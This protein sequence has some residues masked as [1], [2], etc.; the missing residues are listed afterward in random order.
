MKE[1][2]RPLFSLK[3]CLDALD[4]PF[5]RK[6]VSSLLMKKGEIG[7]KALTVMLLGMLTHAEVQIL[8]EENIGKKEKKEMVKHFFQ[9][10]TD[11]SII[12]KINLFIKRVVNFFFQKKNET[13]ILI[14]E[15]ESLFINLT[16][17]ER[18]DLLRAG[19]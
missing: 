10:K 14:K 16:L 4:T 13:D 7:V 2:E 1:D 3:E 5:Q 18:L 11:K 8:P 17:D 19:I 9:K 6:T 12:K 15:V